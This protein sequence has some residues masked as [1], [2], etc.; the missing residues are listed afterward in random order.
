[1]KNFIFV[2]CDFT[3]FLGENNVSEATLQRYSREKICSNFTE[4]HPCRGVKPLYSETSLHRTP[5]G[6][7]NIVRYRELSAT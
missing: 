3:L 2:Q 1:M 4:E 6:P 7:Q 5:S